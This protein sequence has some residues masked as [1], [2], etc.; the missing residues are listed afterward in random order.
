M[1]SGPADKEPAAG[2]DIEH[3]AAVL[4]RR[5]RE[6]AGGRATIGSSSVV[7]A[8]EDAVW[9]GV[10]VPAVVC[11]AAADPLRLRPAEG[12]VTCRRCLRRAMAGRGTRVAQGQTELDV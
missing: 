6:L 9:V 1:S 11:R 3:L 10:R 8:V 4:A 7:H 5:R 12:P 2:A